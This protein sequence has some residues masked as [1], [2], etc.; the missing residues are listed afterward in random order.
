[1]RVV[2][3][4]RGAK[5]IAASEDQTGVKELTVTIVGESSCNNFILHLGCTVHLRSSILARPTLVL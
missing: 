5:A 2:T 3:L 1:M 4:A